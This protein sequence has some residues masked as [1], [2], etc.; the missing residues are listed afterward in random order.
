VPEALLDLAEIEDCVVGGAD[1]GFHVD[2]NP[3]IA[4]DS[5]NPGQLSREVVRTEASGVALVLPDGLRPFGWDHAPA[6]RAVKEGEDGKVR[7]QLQDRLVVDSVVLEDELVALELAEH[8]W[9]SLV[10]LVELPVEVQLDAFEDR[11]EG[12]VFGPPEMLGLEH[13][14]AHPLPAEMGAEVGQLAS[15]SPEL[16][17]PALGGIPRLALPGPAEQDAPLDEGVFLREL[18]ERLGVD[19]V[20]GAGDGDAVQVHRV[21][22]S[23]K[24]STLSRIWPRFAAST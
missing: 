1:L 16:P 6:A 3:L 21:F 8:G 22:S 17:D 10:G 11:S 19:A 14:V 15:E 5:R 24:R 20:V 9:E 4:H 12:P 23:A 2:P 18:D 13:E 7:P